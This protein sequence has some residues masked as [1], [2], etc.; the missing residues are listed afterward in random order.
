MKGWESNCQFDSRPEKVRNRPDLLGCKQGAAYRWKALDESYNLAL[1]LTSIRGL[2]TKLWGLRSRGSAC[3]RDF[4][5]PTWESREIKAIWMWAPWRATK[6]T[7]RG[8]V[9]AFPKSGPW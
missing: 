2:L 1:D 4:G 8:K 9:V 6:Y 5:T 3:W 7:I